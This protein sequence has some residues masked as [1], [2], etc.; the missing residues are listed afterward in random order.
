MDNTDQKANRGLDFDPEALRAKYQQERDKRLRPDGNRQYI[1]TTG[2]YARYAEVDPYVEPGFTR[3]SLT[4]E[5]EVAIIGGGF[6]GLLAGARLREAGVEGIRIIEAGGDFGGTWYWNRYPGCQCDVES[7]IYLPLI[8]E[9]GYMPKEKYAYAK[10]IFEHAKR[11]ATAY[12]LYDDVC[13][14]TRV[15]DMRWDES[16]RRWI[17]RTN[18]NDAIKARFVISA[19]GGVS[20]AKLPGVPGIETFKGHSFHTTRWDYDYTGGDTTGNLHKLGDKRVAIIG[21]GA[22]AIQCVPYVGKYAKHTYVF[23]RTPS[24]VDLRRNHP[25]DPNWAETLKPGWQRERATNFA[26][27]LS[28][29]PVEVDLVNDGWTDIFRNN[30]ASGFVLSSERAQAAPEDLALRAE[31]A[32]FQKMN[33][34]RARV[35]QIVDNKKVAEALKPWYRVFCKR[36]TFNDEYLPTFNRPNVTLVD[37]SEAKGIERITS[38]GVVANGVGYPVD[39]IIY[40]T[41]FEIGNFIRTARFEIYGREGKKLSEYYQHGLRTLHG[42]STSGFPNWFFIGVGQN[43]LSANMTS[44]FDDQAQ[45]IAYIIKEVRSRGVTAVEATPEAE[46]QWVETIRSLVAASKDFLRS[47]TPGYYNNEGDTSSIGIFDQIYTPGINQF[48]AMLAQ[49]R[50]KGDLEGL[51]LLK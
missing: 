13:F 31:L 45:H 7:Y 9:L 49:W 35:D 18:R 22:T 50:D 4:D 46:Q 47:C 41:G 12:R 36:P 10:E 33:S 25:T 6:C 16:M 34:I 11:I 29:R 14:Q 40:A 26:E 30:I 24:F 15:T 51:Q 28:G 43:A 8:E 19:V 5:V 38:K 21:T 48:N 17:I 1:D 39:C 3:E 23:Q 37:V 2:E 20:K 42:H 44:M 32:D 27:I